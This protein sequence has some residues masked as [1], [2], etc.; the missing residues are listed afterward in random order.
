MDLQRSSCAAT[1]YD[2]SVDGLR[3]RL[4]AASIFD[5]CGRPALARPESVEQPPLR[6]CRGLSAAPLVPAPNPCIHCC[7]PFAPRN[8]PKLMQLTQAPAAYAA[9]AHAPMPCLAHLGS[10]PHS[11]SKA[12]AGT[13]VCF[14]KEHCRNVSSLLR[15]S[16]PARLPHLV[17]YRYISALERPAATLVVL[18]LL[19]L[20]PLHSFLQA[21]INS[22]YP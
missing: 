21:I 2:L 8:S 15:F 12:F 13:R 7:L 9:R 10:L 18:P 6:L 20:L 17:S 19:V 3:L 16:I 14:E 1:G 22:S 5:L 11:S 4:R